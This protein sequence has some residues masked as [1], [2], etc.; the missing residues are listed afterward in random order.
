MKVGKKMLNNVCLNGRLTSLPELRYTPNGVAICDFTLAVKRNYSSENG[1]ELTD[2]IRC[3]ALKKTA[4]TIGNHVK[5]GHL[6]GVEGSIQTRHYDNDAGVR[7]YVTE[8]FIRQFHFLEKKESS[9]P[10]NNRSN[11]YR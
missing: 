1:E 9:A 3:V 7:I 10:Q 2:F 5:K 11:D 8:V 4:E 6:I